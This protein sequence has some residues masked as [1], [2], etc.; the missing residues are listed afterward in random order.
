[1]LILVLAIVNIPVY[2]FI[3]WLIFD[4]KDK[5]TET[6]V[7]TIVAV[8][9][10]I[11]VPKIVRYLFGMDDEGAWGLLPIAAFFVACGLIV[12]GEYWLIKQWL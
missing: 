1:M 9:Q 12:Y 4:S 8:L 5:A 2:L 11:F 7:E 3:A 10:I 6:F